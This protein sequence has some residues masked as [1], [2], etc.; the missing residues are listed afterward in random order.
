MSLYT[1]V[2]H[3][4]LDERALRGPVN[5]DPAWKGGSRSNPLLPERG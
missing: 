4:H 3:P 2:R 5:N 1:E